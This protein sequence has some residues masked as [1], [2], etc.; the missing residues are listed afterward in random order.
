MSETNLTLLSPLDRLCALFANRMN[1][2]H[3][4]WGDEEIL[5]KIRHL[6]LYTEDSPTLDITWTKTW[7]TEDATFQQ[8]FFHSPFEHAIFPEE[9][10]KAYV[11]FILP[12]AAKKTAPIALHFAA[13]GDQGFLRRRNLMALPLLPAGIGS[14]ILE[15]PFYGRR[16]PPTQQGFSPSRV[17]DLW[18]M[19]NA[20]IY[21][22][23]ALLQWLKK[24]NYNHLAVTGISMGG[25]I[26]AVVASLCSLEIA[27]IPCLAPHS[28]VT[29]F[30]EG[31]LTKACNWNALAETLA[32]NKKAHDVLRD[33]LADSDI[34][35]YPPPKKTK[36]AIIVAGQYDAYVLPY[37]PEIIHQRWQ[38][39]E[40]RWL[41]TGHVGAFFFQRKHFLTA[42]RDAIQ[43]L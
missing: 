8:G 30:T 21:E 23:L 14:L 7:E 25:Y 12:K 22:G 5:Q 38:G 43:R 20:A 27:A 15:N 34:R 35:H 28:A 3:Q 41:K 17:I 16:R 26:A 39:S 32:Q 11:E 9:S 40:I 13:T 4:G 19:A 36:A 6:D 37:S 31:V 24:E 29:V 2:F 42:I 10:Q 1:F 18:A 33:F